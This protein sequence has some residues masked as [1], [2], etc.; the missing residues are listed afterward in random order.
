LKEKY[1]SV[2]QHNVIDKIFKLAE[3]FKIEL[4]VDGLNTLSNSASFYAD[5]Q[6]GLLHRG[7]GFKGRHH[8][9]AYDVASL[10]ALFDESTRL[11]SRESCSFDG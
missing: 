7:R 9:E 3:I 4:I 5:L 8:C 11:A 1:K 10:L 2:Y 6:Q